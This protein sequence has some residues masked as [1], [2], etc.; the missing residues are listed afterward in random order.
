MKP[1][2]FVDFYRTLNHEI[3]WRSLPSNLQKKVEE[4]LFANNKA[5]INDWMRG[6]YTSEE[7]NKL[8]AKKLN[9]PFDYLWEIFVKDCKTMLVSE[10]TLKKIAR[11]RD[12][13]IVV[14]ITGNMDSFNAYTIPALKLEK[15]FD[16]ISN[17]FDE[18]KHKND[19]EGILFR[20]YSKKFN[21]PLSKSF[22]IDDSDSVCKI[23]TALGGTAYKVD[24]EKDADYYLD[25]LLAKKY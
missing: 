10:E 9:V 23:F 4:F 25:A 13:F 3:Y 12:K 7:I 16:Y 2:L 17:S 8:L 5:V 1:I 24:E 14:L 18:K 6:E 11:L 19:E 15:Y 22:L 21:S 20:E